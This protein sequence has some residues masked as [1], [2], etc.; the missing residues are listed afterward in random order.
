MRADAGKAAKWKGLAARGAGMGWGWGGVGEWG[1][2][3]GG[4]CGRDPLVRV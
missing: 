3:C 2:E 1:V 4:G